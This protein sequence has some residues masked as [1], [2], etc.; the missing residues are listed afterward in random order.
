[1]RV[2]GGN[3]H[4]CDLKKMLLLSSSA[5]LLSGI[6]IVVS[7]INKIH[8]NIK[9]TDWNYKVWQIFMYLDTMYDSS[10]W[11]GCHVILI[12][13]IS[14]KDLLVLSIT[15]PLPTYYW[16]CPQWFCNF[17][18]IFIFCFLFSNWKKTN[19]SPT[20][21]GQSFDLII[22]DRVL[23]ISYLK[24]TRKLTN[25]FLKG[26]KYLWDYLVLSILGT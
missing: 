8:S 23:L 10:T 18:H 6:F 12:L 5:Y 26:S 15:N 9:V 11:C 3:Y 1:M 25:E 4:K 13:E 20:N 2:V 22:M 19:M 24:I 16:H 7:I 17:F 21:F 14:G